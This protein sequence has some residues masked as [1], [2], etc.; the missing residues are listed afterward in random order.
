MSQFNNC[1][2]TLNSIYIT[3]CNVFP[4]KKKKG[5]RA[6][7]LWSLCQMKS[8][9]HRGSTE[10]QGKCFPTVTP[11][12]RTV[13]ASTVLTSDSVKDQSHVKHNSE[14]QVPFLSPKLLSP[15][16]QSHP[17]S[18][19]SDIT[20]SYKRAARPNIV[21]AILHLNIKTRLTLFLQ[22]LLL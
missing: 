16:S 4:K 13:S 6:G 17:L 15:W 20:P 12:S 22:L 10:H 1:C 14:S 7:G 19:P 11:G 18:W 21:I 3:A 2:F 5:L 8:V 9:G